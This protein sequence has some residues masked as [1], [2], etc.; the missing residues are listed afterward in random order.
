MSVAIIV[1]G[2]L[3]AATTETPLPATLL[4]MNSLQVSALPEESFDEVVIDCLPTE[5]N[6]G[7]AYRILRPGGLLRVR[8]PPADTVEID[9]RIAGFLD[10]AHTEDDLTCRKPQWRTGEKAA[11]SSVPVR[12]GGVLQADDLLDDLVDEDALLA[13]TAASVPTAASGCGT[14][15]SGGKK[16]ACKDCT[17]GELPLQSCA[18]PQF[19]T[20]FLGLA[21]E[22]RQGEGGKVTLTLEEKV[23]RAGSCGGCYR[24]DAFRCGSCPFLGLPAFEPGQE[25]VV[26]SLT[27]D[28]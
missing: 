21:E 27:A 25:R 18:V 5:M 26:L 16:R 22:E 17:C 15:T 2:G 1:E 19:V 6:I 3:R 11:L 10:L 9:L 7:V 20:Q 24:G 23:A 12:K 8:L 14:G 28:I 13:E 4:D